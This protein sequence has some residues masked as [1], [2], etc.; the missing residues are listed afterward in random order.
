MTTSTEDRPPGR[1]ETTARGCRA[2]TDHDR[3]VPEIDLLSPLTLRGVTL[4]NRI[5][6]SP[7]CQYSAEDGMANDWHLVHLGSRAVGGAGLV[8]VEATAVT[9]EGRISP[10]DLGIWSDA[11]AE[12][13]GRIARFVRS[14][15]AAAGIQLAHAGRKASSNLPWLGGGP[16]TTTEEGGWPVVAPSAVPFDEGS[17]VPTALDAAGV[18][19]IVDAFEAAASRAVDAGFNVLEIHAAHGYLLHEFLSPLSNRRDDE[20]GGG[21]ENRMRLVLRVTERLRQ[22]TPPDLP[23]FVRISATDWAEGGWDIEQSIELARRLKDLGVDLVDV[24]SGGLVPRVTI[25]VAKRYQVPFARRIR[26]E[27]G[28]RTGAVGLITEPGEACDIITGG[29]ANLVFIARELLREPYWA[30]KAQQALGEEPSWPTPYGYAVKR[31]AR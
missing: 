10:G 16:L 20:Y 28:V 17:P 25:P 15:G 7:M 18:D 11:H 6:V 2:D 19:A 3:E 1:A 9:P 5:V 31:R 29:D 21:I 27:A 14:Q 12:P 22:T 24:S 23:L 30:I 8:F 13:L 26:D 4:R